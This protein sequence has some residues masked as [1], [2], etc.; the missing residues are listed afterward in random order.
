MHWQSCEG[1]QDWNSRGHSRSGLMCT[2]R[3]SEEKHV[4][5]LPA[6]FIPEINTIWPSFDVQN[7]TVFNQIRTSYRC[8]VNWPNIALNCARAAPAGFHRQI[9]LA[10]EGRISSIMF[11]CLLKLID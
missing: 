4:Q 2:R 6:L 7:S 8:V 11:N 5:H 10:S 3:P 9:I 1:E